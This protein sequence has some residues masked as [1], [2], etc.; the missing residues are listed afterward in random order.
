[1]KATLR[2]N[3]KITLQ[4]DIK[5]CLISWKYNISSFFEDGD[6][7]LFD[8]QKDTPGQVYKLLCH[9]EQKHVVDRVRRRVLLAVLHKLL[10]KFERNRLHEE[11]LNELAS[12]VFQ[13]GLVG[14]DIGVVLNRLAEWTKKGRRYNTLAESLGSSGSFVLLPFEIG[15]TM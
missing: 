14:K 1:M 13:S 12:A 7:L 3:I 2:S 11:A 10:E 6:G 5:Q 9:L 8:P 4:H 15:D